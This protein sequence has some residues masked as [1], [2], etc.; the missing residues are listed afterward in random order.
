MSRK[1]RGRETELLLAKYLESHGWTGVHAP[2]SSAPG[3]DIIGMEGVDWEC[4]ARRGFDPSA[5]ISQI[6]ARSKETGL[7]V[8]VLRLNGQGPAAIDDWLCCMR[9]SDVVYLLKA[10]GYGQR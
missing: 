10:A 8:A 3:S 7:G 2:S 6:R 1:A 9:L 4:K 5:A